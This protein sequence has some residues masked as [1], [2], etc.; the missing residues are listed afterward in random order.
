MASKPANAF[1]MMFAAQKAKQGSAGKAAL[2][3]DDAGGDD[4]ELMGDDASTKSKTPVFKGSG[5]GAG[6]RHFVDPGTSLSGQPERV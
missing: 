3:Q 1:Q 2:A 4:D 6:P 5:L